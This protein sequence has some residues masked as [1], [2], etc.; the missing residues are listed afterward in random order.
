M[1]I[2]EMVV[3]GVLVLIPFASKAQDKPKAAAPSD[4]A[5]GKQTYMEHCAACH[6]ADGRGHGPAASALKTPPPN[7]RT[8]AI[9]HEGKFPE[10]YVA[11]VVRVGDPLLGHGSSEMPIWGPVFS[12]EE[13]GN[14]MGLQRRI[15]NLCDYL[16]SIQDKKS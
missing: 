13:N 12:M 8:L 3:A 6:G 16:A 1:K 7:L 15:Q 14:E 2:R 10:T 5:S 11:R 4:V 9:R